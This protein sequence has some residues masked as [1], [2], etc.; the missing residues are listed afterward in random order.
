MLS[1]N[2]IINSLKPQLKCFI[3]EGLLRFQWISV[4]WGLA[5]TPAG[6]H[7]SCP[8]KNYRIPPIFTYILRANGLINGST[9]SVSKQVPI[10][11]AN[12]RH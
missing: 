9:L 10:W 12:W 4:G 1:K 3:G 5:W 2:S 8:V 6:M 11:N 7:N